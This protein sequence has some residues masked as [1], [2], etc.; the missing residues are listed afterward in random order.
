MASL[1]EPLVALA[2]GAML[3]LTGLLKRRG[4]TDL[5]AEVRQDIELRQMLEMNQADQEARTALTLSIQR[6]T[7]P[8][9]SA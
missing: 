5:R 2:V 8:T 4:G 3:A 7:T 9:G 1:I 6:N